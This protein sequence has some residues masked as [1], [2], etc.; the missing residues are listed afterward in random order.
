MFYFIFCLFCFRSQDSDNPVYCSCDK[1]AKINTVTKPGSNQGRHFYSCSSRECNFFLWKEA[2]SDVP[3]W[4][5]S[6]NEES[7]NNQVECKCHQQ[8]K[9]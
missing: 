3:V 8:A 5:M 1:S 7:T 6:N 9:M 4:L 2:E